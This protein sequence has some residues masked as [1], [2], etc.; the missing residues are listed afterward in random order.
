MKKVLCAD[1][2]CGGGG[3]STG[4]INAFLEAGIEYELVGVN[5]WQIAIDTN[6]LNHDKARYVRDSVETISPRE[7]VPGGRLDFLWASPEC[8]NHSRA[9]GGRPRDDQSRSTAWHVLKWIQELIIDRV[10]IENVSEFLEW[11]PVDDQ[12]KVIASKKGDIFKKF[13]AMIKAF[14]YRVEWRI[15]NAADF[16]APTCRNR[17][18][19]QAVRGKG[20]LQWPEPTHVKE[21]GL[22]AGL[23]QPWVPARDIIDWNIPGQSIFDRKKPL[24]PNTLRRI[25]SGI[26]KYWGSGAAL[27]APLVKQ[28]IIRSCRHYKKCPLMY[29]YHLPELKKQGVEEPFVV[30]MRGTAAEQ[31]APSCKAISEPVPAISTRNHASIIEPFVARYNGGDNRH[32]TVWDP[33]PVQ[34][35]SNRYGIVQPVVVTLRGTDKAHIDGSCKP[36]S[37]TAPTVAANGTHIGVVEP[38]VFATGHTSG[39]NRAS[40]MNE[41]I[42]TIVTKAEHC[43]VAPVIVDMTHT[44]ERSGRV[45]SAN[46][47]VNAI[48]TRNNFAIAEAMFI[49]QNGGGSV[50]PVSNPLSTIATEGAISQIEPFIAKYYSNGTAESVNEPLDTVTCKERFGLCSC[51]IFTD[52]RGNAFKLDILFRMFQPKELAAAMSFPADYKFAGNKGDIVKQIGNAVPPVMAKALV[53]AALS[54]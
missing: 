44:A 35:C 30:V 1:L 8:T 5:H 13:I 47:P 24:V 52:A 9:K 32:S 16:G 3:T 36:D 43:L 53:T 33:V 27:Y 14:G 41:P 10:Y 22:L 20:K 49:P 11:G 2:F 34:D 39:G 28:E 23:Y 21:P 54:A 7:L 51:R 40:G 31:D 46:D 48:T 12:G 45:K 29:L 19:I 25:Y 26:V 17:L 38:C 15:L 4:M 18:I 37:V 6:Q 50:K 42:S